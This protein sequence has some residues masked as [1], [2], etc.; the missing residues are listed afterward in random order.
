MLDGPQPEVIVR[1]IDNCGIYI[2]PLELRIRLYL[3]KTARSC[4]RD[5]LDCTEVS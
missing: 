1:A 3:E 2:A 4:Q 5:S